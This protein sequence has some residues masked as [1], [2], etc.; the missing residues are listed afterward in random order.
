[1]AIIKGFSKATRH[2]YAQMCPL[3][4]RWWQDR[5]NILVDSVTFSESLIFYLKNCV[6]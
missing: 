3:S 5:E 6:F 1:M 4:Y 2:N